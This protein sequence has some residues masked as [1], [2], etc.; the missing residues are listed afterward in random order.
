[1]SIWDD[2]FGVVGLATGNPNAAS[3]QDTA[4]ATTAATAPFQDV[5][6]ALTAAYDAITNFYMWRSLGWLLLGLVVMIL[7]V[8][9][10]LKGQIASQVG[11]IAGDAL[12]GVA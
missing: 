11:S 4:D 8:A 3:A 9:L 7:G 10:L 12:G 6:H 5:S 2:I 1:M